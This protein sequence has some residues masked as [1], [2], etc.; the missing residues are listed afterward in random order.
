M[1][2]ELANRVQQSVTVIEIRPFRG[3]WQCYEGEGVG[4]YWI[5]DTA[6]QSAAEYAKARAKFGRGEIRVLR[7]DGSVESVIGI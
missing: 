7:Q 1:M 4:P 3:G 6:K 5:G 2:P